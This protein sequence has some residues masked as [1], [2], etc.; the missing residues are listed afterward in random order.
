MKCLIVDDE[1]LARQLLASYIERVE[2]LTL[3]KSCANAVEAFTVIQQR[4]VDLIFLDIQM[5]QVTGIDLLKSL[6]DRPRVILTTAY[7]E[8]AF[9]AYDLDVVDY[10]LKPILFERFLRGISKIYQLRQ[11]MEMEEPEPSLLQSFDDAYIYL[12][13]DREM[14]KV[15][16]KDILYIESLRDYVKVKTVDKQIVTYQKISYLEQKLPENKFI[17]V[18]RSFIVAFDKVISFNMNSVKVGN[19]EIPMG[20]NYKNQALKVLNRNNVLH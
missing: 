13:E 20:R 11:P 18:H 14:M 19:I 17:R 12:R 4:P 2:G 1:P 3:V 16:L 9:E 7:R 5:P 10:M 6:K 15:Y 8:Y